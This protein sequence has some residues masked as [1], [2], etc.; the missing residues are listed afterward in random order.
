MTI[1]QIAILAQGALWRQ[2]TEPAS[3]PRRRGDDPAAAEKAAELAMLA[4][5]LAV[6]QAL[7]EVG[8][9]HLSANTS[10]V[11]F[12]QLIEKRSPF[13]RVLPTLRIA[14]KWLL[15]N[16]IYLAQVTAEIDTVT[17]GDDGGGIASAMRSFWKAYAAFAATLG[18]SYPRETLP[19]QSIPLDE[20]RD[21]AGFLPLRLKRKP[22]GEKNVAH[23]GGAE[24]A[25]GEKGGAEQQKI[26]I[27]D[28]LRDALELTH[29]QV[30]TMARQFGT[31]R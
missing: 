4:H 8:T 12:A 9:W 10:A 26:R 18:A 13:V 2:R 27:A 30:R 24:P 28:L 15:G 6:H 7:W 21:I 20:D 11:D 14:S 5:L 1:P 23:A 31:K 25:Q 19:A 16:T 29:T 22:A 17:T 3:R